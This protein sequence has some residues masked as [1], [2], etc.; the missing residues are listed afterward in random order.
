MWLANGD[1]EDSASNPVGLRTSNGQLE[2]YRP[3][4]PWRALSVRRQRG[5]RSGRSDTS[6]KWSLFVVEQQRLNIAATV[7][8]TNNDDLGI[9]EAIIQHVIT[10]EVRPQ[11]LGYMISTW[12]DLRMGQKSGKTLFNLADKLRGSSA[13]IPCDETPEIDQILF[14]ALSYAEGS[15]SCNCCSPFL[16]M[17]SGSK[18]C[19]RPA[20][21][22]ASPC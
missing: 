8:H 2:I 21:M 4:E 1:R 16:M 6:S 22:S 5:V 17:R 7:N 13:I 3:G 18:S 10:V 19:T 11:T 14:C 9:R 20:S 12:A 15:V